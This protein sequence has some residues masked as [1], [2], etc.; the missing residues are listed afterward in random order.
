MLH[1]N[2]TWTSC[3]N[4]IFSFAHE[5][6]FV[7][8]TACDLCPLTLLISDGEENDCEIGFGFENVSCDYETC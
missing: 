6:D 4:V 2:G 7:T 8:V 3:W 1:K 5:N